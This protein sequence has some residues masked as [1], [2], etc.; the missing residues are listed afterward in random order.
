MPLCEKRH[1]RHCALAAIVASLSPAVEPVGTAIDEDLA[2]LMERHVTAGDGFDYD[3]PLSWG[4][5]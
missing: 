3:G 4:N 1:L 5:V 2:E